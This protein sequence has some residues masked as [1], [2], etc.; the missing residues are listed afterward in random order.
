VLEGV[1]NAAGKRPY[2]FGRCG[3]P[4]GAGGAAGEGGTALRL[5]AIAMLT[6]LPGAALAD[7]TL[8]CGLDGANQVAIGDCLAGVETVVDRT[9]AEALGFAMEAA[10]ALDGETGHPAAAPALEAGQAAWSAYR[11]A[12]CAYVGT[13]WG[14][15]SGEGGAVRA[16]RIDLGRDRVGVLMGF[17]G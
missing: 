8:E 13:T 3:G 2:D 4:A 16:C 17:A 6:L 7:P 10:K 11:E 15:G 9:V 12:H 1:W 14:G 5:L